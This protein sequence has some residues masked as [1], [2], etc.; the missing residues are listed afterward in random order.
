MCVPVPR[1][2]RCFSLPLTLFSGPPEVLKLKVQRGELGETDGKLEVG[3]ALLAA[4]A[5]ADSSA[6]DRYLR[7]SGEQ[8]GVRQSTFWGGL[9]HQSN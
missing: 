4:S 2:D 8:L 6:I 7:R 3:A 9:P 5:H 1:D